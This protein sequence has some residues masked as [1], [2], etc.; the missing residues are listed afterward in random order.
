MTKKKTMIDFLL[1]FQSYQLFNL[2]A[3]AYNKLLKFAHGIKSNARSPIELQSLINSLVTAYLRTEVN[4]ENVL[5]TYELRRGRVE[6]N[7]IPQT[8]MKL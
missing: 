3:R 4:I 7:V 6:I 5:D 1:N 8:N 2:Q